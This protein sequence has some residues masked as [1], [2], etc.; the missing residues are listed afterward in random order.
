[1][2]TERRNNPYDP[3]YQRELV[4]RMQRQQQG[5]P[6]KA[7]DTKSEP[8]TARHYEEYGPKA[9]N[10]LFRRNLIQ[11]NSATPSKIKVNFKELTNI[12][13]YDT[14][15]ETFLF[16]KAVDCDNR[17]KIQKGVSDQM[18]DIVS[19]FIL[20]A[21]AKNVHGVKWN[22]SADWS[23][24]QCKDYYIQHKGWMT[25]VASFMD[26]KTVYDNFEAGLAEIS[27]KRWECQKSFTDYKTR[28]FMS[29]GEWSLRREKNVVEVVKEIQVARDIQAKLMDEKESVIETVSPAMRTLV[30][31]INP[32]LSTLLKL[33][34]QED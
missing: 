20:T 28:V 26:E 33:S 15:V 1:M 9:L 32:D 14:I 27:M 13:I 8:S 31:R 7:R 17:S 11:S 5:I 24:N 34:Q 3:E 16:D 21:Y 18:A 4:E 6:A 2:S 22:V 25:P 29:I 19:R 23:L 12:Q 10:E 30:D